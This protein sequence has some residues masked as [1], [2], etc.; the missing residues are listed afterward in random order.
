VIV[1]DEESFAAWQNFRRRRGKLS[2][3]ALNQLASRSKEI[4]TTLSC[5]GKDFFLN[6]RVQGRT[7]VNRPVLGSRLLLLESS[8]LA[9]KGKT[10]ITLNF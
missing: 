2:A 8:R 7:F 5:S 4:G 3:V 9:G 10:Q 6:P 1:E